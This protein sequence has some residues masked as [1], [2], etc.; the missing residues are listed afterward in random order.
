MV[1]ATE[2]ARREPGSPR[3]ARLRCMLMS[4]ERVRVPVVD[5]R[6]DPVTFMQTIQW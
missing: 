3:R 1:G 6:D 4:M 2:S 5:S